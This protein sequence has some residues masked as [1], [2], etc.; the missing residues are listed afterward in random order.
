MKRN[1]LTLAVATLLIGSSAFAQGKLNKLKEK[2]GEENVKQVEAATKEK[3]E[4][5]KEDDVQ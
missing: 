5:V 2:V 4:E 3:V 1:I